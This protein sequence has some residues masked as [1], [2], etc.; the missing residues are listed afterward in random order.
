MRRYPG[1]FAGVAFMEAVTRPASW[2]EF[3]RAENMFRAL[4]SPAGEQMILDDN[5]FVERILP[6][7]ILRTLS[8]EEMANYRAPFRER[9]SRWPT[10]VWPR[11]IPIDGEPADVV[12]IVQQ[13]AAF[14]SHSPIPKL[15]IFGDPGSFLGTVARETTR[16]WPNQQQVTVKGVHFLQEDSP[17][18][19]GAAL[20]DFVRRVRA[21]R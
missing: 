15:A 1:H 14:L 9:E 7:S 20:A 17:D 5:L 6:A 19:I 16:E 4:R 2:S 11:Q 18:E 21:E 3:G 12:D 13:F 8:D 10:L